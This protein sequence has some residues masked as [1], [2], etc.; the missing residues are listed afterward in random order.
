MEA[1][2][3]SPLQHLNVH[4]LVDMV[5][6]IE[7][8]RTLTRNELADRL[9]PD[10]EER[11]QELPRLAADRFDSGWRTLLTTFAR[12]IE[13]PVDEEVPDGDGEHVMDRLLQTD[14]EFIRDYGVGLLMDELEAELRERGMVFEHG[15]D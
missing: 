11:K 4:D 13:N 14:E 9:G 7:V 2:R 5:Y 6:A 8:V 15:D 12:G 1:F 3:P 10:F